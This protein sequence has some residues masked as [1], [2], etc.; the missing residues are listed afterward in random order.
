MEEHWMMCHG[1]WSC[2]D[3]TCAFPCKEARSVRQTPSTVNGSPAPNGHI[4]TPPEPLL[5][6]PGLRLRSPVEDGWELT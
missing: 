2:L 4:G 1:R 3:C 6:I 5:E